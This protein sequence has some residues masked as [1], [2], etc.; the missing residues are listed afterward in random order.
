[1]FADIISLVVVTGGRGGLQRTISLQKTIMPDLLKN[2]KNCQ[3]KRVLS[4][5]NWEA[6]VNV[7]PEN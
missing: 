7:Y 4:K 6:K 1:M 3:E 5:S 2:I